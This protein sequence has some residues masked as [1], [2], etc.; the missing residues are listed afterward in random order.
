MLTVPFFL[1][2]SVVIINYMFSYATLGHLVDSVKP[3]GKLMNMV[4]EI[5]IYALNGKK[6]RGATKRVMPLHVSVSSNFF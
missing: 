2:C 5:G 1:P 4:A 3:G 6:M